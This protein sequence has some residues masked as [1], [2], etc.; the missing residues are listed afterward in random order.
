MA[1]R[2]TAPAPTHTESLAIWRTACVACGQALHAAQHT[3]RTI[4]RLDWVWHLR[5]VLHRCLNPHCA[6]FRRLCRPEKEGAWALP[7]GEFGFD[8]I[9]LIG[10]SRYAQ[11][12]S[13]PEIHHDLVTRGVLIAERTVTNLLAHAPNP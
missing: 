8:V 10:Q 2:T 5:F 3:Q 7:H 13:I 9:V 6:R 11:H 12:R 1:W 4:R